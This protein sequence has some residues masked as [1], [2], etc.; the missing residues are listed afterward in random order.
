[1][2]IIYD[3]SKLRGLIVE[4]FKNLENFADAI[5][6]GRTTLNNKLQCY[7]YFTQIEIERICDILEIARENR[8]IYFFTRK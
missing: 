5:P 8:N 3:Y 1:M 6:M 4:K 7:T 2:K